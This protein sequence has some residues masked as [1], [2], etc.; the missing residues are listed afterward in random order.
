MYGHLNLSWNNS[1]S[2]SVF[3][4]MEGIGNFTYSSSGPDL[5]CVN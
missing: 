3:V 5:I 4:K 1:N 2:E